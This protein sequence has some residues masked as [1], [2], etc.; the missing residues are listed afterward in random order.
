MRRNPAGDWTMADIERECRRLGLSVAPPRGGGSHWKVWYAGR[1]IS[2]TI[3]ARRPLKPVYVRLFV[4]LVD[5][6]GVEE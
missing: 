5:E 3:P 1:P 4:A 2:L 6:S